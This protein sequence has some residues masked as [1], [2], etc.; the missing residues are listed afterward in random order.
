MIVVIEG[1]KKDGWLQRGFSLVKLMRL[2]DSLAHNDTEFGGQVIDWLWWCPLPGESRVDNGRL[3]ECCVPR[4]TA[5]LG[6]S[7]NS[8]WI[9]WN[10][11]NSVVTKG[12]ITTGQIIITFS[13]INVK[14]CGVIKPS[15]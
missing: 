11:N 5:G 2:S 7:F 3:D 9:K 12:K 15:R 8:A 14:V 10:K 1:G 13:V 6:T 4:Q